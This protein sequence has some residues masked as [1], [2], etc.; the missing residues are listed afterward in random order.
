[1]EIKTVIKTEREYKRVLKRASELM[2]LPDGSPEDVELEL[3]ALLIDDYE[4]RHYPIE[5]PE[6]VE[7]IKFRME[8]RGYTKKDLARIL[9][10]QNRASE[11]LLKKRT[12][13]LNMIRRLTEEWNMSAD[14]LIGNTR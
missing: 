2:D 12:L 13:T 10:G 5:P 1:M 9:G 6:P 3:L 7:A 4:R 14:I 11:I 8:Q